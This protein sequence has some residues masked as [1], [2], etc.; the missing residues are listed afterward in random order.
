MKTRLTQN[1]LPPK[2]AYIEFGAPYALATPPDF[3]FQYV[4]EVIWYENRTKVISRFSYEDRDTAQKEYLKAQKELCGPLKED[5][6][7]KRGMQ[8][9]RD[10]AKRA[11][12]NFI[13]LQNNLENFYPLR[14]Y[15]YMERLRRAKWAREKRKRE[16]RKIMDMHPSRANDYIAEKMKIMDDA[17]IQKS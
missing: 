5:L 2:R 13:E 14:L 8:R 6:A 4:Y 10:A 7:L 12:E 16:K 9:T 11:R 15:E 3:T 1:E 17:S